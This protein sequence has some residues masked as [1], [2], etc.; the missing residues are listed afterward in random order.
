MFTR[1]GK[2]LKFQEDN[3]LLKGMRSEWIYPEKVEEKV[4]EA[5]EVEEEVEDITPK[6]DESEEVK[7][8]IKSDISRKAFIEWVND[9]FYKS[10][11]PIKIRQCTR[12]NKNS[13]SI[14]LRN[15]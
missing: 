4:E 2:I 7:D 12:R 3:D 13:I 14:L 6:E 9:V 15:I 10:I 8:L 11:R 5:Q 1:H